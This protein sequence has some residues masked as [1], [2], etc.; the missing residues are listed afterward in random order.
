MALFSLVHRTN[1]S[2]VGYFAHGY[3]LIIMAAIIP[4]ANN[5]VSLGKKIKSSS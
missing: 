3:I 1:F 4:V 5:G 2:Y